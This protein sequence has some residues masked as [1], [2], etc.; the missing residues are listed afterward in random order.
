MPSRVVYVVLCRFTGVPDSEG[1]K[2]MPIVGFEKECDAVFY[3]NRMIKIN[4][5]RQAAHK[6]EYDLHSIVIFE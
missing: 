4:E 1:S 5:E 2:P 3:M 6:Y